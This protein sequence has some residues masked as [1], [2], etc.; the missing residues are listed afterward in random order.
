MLKF[1]GYSKERG[2]PLFGLGFTAENVTRLHTQ[3]PLTVNLAELGGP[4]DTVHL[5]HVAT[6]AALLDLMEQAGKVDPVLAEGITARGIDP[7]WPV[8]LVAADG[9][10]RVFLIALTG[11]GLAVVLRTRLLEVVLP[12]DEA[13]GRSPVLLVY[14]YAPDEK[15]LYALVEEAGLLPPG[16][17]FRPSQPRAVIDLL[18]PSGRSD[19][20]YPPRKKRR[21]RR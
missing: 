2:M 9:P 3:G 14:F 16:A 1:R 7:E 19:R 17:E 4:D 10:R 12:A 5:L 13:L 21:K 11:T 6:P 8:I 18:D 20:P 15:A